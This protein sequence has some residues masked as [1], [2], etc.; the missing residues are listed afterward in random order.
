MNPWR[1]AEV[2]VAIVVAIAG[3]W[4]GSPVSRVNVRWAHEAEFPPPQPDDPI[5]FWATMHCKLDGEPAPEQ[6]DALEVFARA[7]L[8][9]DIDKLT[10]YSS[11]TLGIEVRANDACARPDHPDGSF[12]EI[13]ITPRSK[14]GELV[15]AQRE[16]FHG[17]CTWGADIVYCLHVTASSTGTAVVVEKLNSIIGMRTATTSA[18]VASTADR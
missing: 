5:R 4:G 8:L 17:H 14:L 9:A 3:C 11:R 16:L 7:N 10:G 13:V 1:G 15:V 2:M 18:S 12:T 6:R